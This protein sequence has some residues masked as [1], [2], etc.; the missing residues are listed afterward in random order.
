MKIKS[1]PH[2]TLLLVLN[3]AFVEPTL[4]FRL[5]YIST[6]KHSKLY[7]KSDINEEQALPN[8]RNPFQIRL[9]HFL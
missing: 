7:L 1:I 5:I 3:T 4:A 8:P 9:L 2:L 6:I